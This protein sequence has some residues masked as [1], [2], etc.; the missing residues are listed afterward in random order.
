MGF[1][2]LIKTDGTKSLLTAINYSGQLRAVVDAKL[3]IMFNLTLI[4]VEIEKTSISAAITGVA[5]MLMT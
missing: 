2:K 5:K 3:E 1:C 4:Q